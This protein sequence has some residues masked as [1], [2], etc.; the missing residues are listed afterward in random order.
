MNSLITAELSYDDNAFERV[1]TSSIAYWV[2]S[3][4]SRSRSGNEVTILKR[5][6]FEAPVR[7]WFQSA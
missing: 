5:A 6:G 1:K 7:G 3:R 4:R 2:D